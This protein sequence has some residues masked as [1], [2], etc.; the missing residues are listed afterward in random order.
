M[1]EILNYKTPNILEDLFCE[2]PSSSI[3][4]HNIKE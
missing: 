4:S 1:E 3:Y 2:N